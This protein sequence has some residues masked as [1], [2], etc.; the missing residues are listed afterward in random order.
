M[1]DT[2]ALPSFDLDGRV[3]IVT[4]GSRGLGR[5]ICLAYAAA[6][7]KL[8]VASRKAEACDEVAAEIVDAGGEAIAVPTHVGRSEQLAQLVETTVG[9]FGGISIVVNN[10]ANPL[11]GSLREMTDLAFEK[12]F[13][14]NVRGPVQL[15]TLALDHLAAS[16]HGVVINMITA[17]AFQPGEGLGLYCSGKAALWSFTR[18]MAKEFAPMGVRVNALA[19]GPFETN[20]MA[21]TLAVPEFTQHI[22]DATL[23]KRVADPAEIGGAAVFLAS[24]ASS[25]MTGSALSIDGGLLA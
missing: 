14:T 6:G 21:A 23:L 8:V 17:G 24:D 3:A 22:I 12:S 5:A 1:T 18:V 25:Y 2:P 15:A 4:G 10:A 19:P 16:G 11:G 9:H 20:M 13:A 7:A